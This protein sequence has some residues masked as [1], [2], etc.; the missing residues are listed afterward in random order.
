M[1]A[2]PGLYSVTLVVMVSGA[3]MAVSCSAG[4][5]EE[6]STTATLRYGKFGAFTAYHRAASDSLSGA[7][8]DPTGTWLFDNIELGSLSEVVP[9]PEPATASLVLAAGVVFGAFHLRRRSS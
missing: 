1:L 6:V 8:Y 3:G 9:V 5:L 4:V 7:A 2:F